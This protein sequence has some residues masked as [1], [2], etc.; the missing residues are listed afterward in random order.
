MS[1]SLSPPLPQWRWALWLALT[2]VALAGC[3][4]ELGECDKRAAEEIVYSREGLVAT[5][6]QALLH[7]S[8]G[9]GSTCH[10]AAATGKNRLG[11]PSGLDLDVLPR[12]SKL[13]KVLQQREEI[14]EQVSSELMPPRGHVVAD[15]EWSFDRS[16]PEKAPFLAGLATTEGKAALRNWLACGAPSVADGKVPAWAR[17]TEPTVSAVASEWSELQQTLR[18]TC[19]AAGCHDGS[20][21]PSIPEWASTPIGSA[22]AASFPDAAVPG[23][24]SIPFAAGECAVYK[25]LLYRR[26]ACGERLVVGGDPAASSLVDRLESERPRCGASMPPREHMVEAHVLSA[27]AQQVR[28]WVERGAYAPQCGEWSDRAPRTAGLDAGVNTPSNGWSELHKKIIGPRCATAG[29]HVAQSAAAA[30]QLDLSERCA[31]RRALLE[32]KGPCGVR[33]VP[34]D[35]SSMLIDKVAS[36]SPRCNAR[37]PPGVPLSDGDLAALR[38]WVASG[39]DG[40]DC[41]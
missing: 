26:D 10:A 27:L 1:D 19:T 8:C 5:K 20:S 39:A 12:P 31:A 18:R 22:P 34:G 16:R 24:L 14:W 35:V 2:I 13:A 9:R 40:E 36:E 6:G 7:D 3:R 11:A 41:P 37:M 21:D 38:A 29:C 28:G 17:Q 32:D 4:A 23:M 30:G 25:W 15:G 33:V